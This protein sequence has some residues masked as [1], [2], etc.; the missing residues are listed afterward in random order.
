MRSLC[1]HRVYYVVVLMLKSCACSRAEMR[2]SQFSG[3]QQLLRAQDVSYETG[4]MIS[5][6]YISQ[7]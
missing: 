3:Q 4:Q 5:F 7:Q 2:V 6:C 1:A